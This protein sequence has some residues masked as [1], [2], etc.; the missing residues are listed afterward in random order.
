[1]SE[2]TGSGARHFLQP[3]V[4]VTASL[5]LPAY[6][7]TSAP[8]KVRASAQLTDSDGDVSRRGGD[9]TAGPSV[10]PRGTVPCPS[11][12]RRDTPWRIVWIQQGRQ[13]T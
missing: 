5:W 12:D 1:M 11:S 13:D 6:L 8:A 9:L 7:P 4:D 10:R 2:V 3:M